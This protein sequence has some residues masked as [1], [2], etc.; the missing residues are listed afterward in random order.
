MLLKTL[1]H[2]LDLQYPKFAHKLQNLIMWILLFFA[3]LNLIKYQFYF[4]QII[5]KSI[6]NFTFQLMI[7]SII[8][9]DQFKDF[10]ES[11]FLQI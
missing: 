3:F 7:F 1:H 2:N 6:G 5:Q 11:K 10:K 8:L 4:Y 9:I